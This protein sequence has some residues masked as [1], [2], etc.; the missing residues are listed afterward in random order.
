MLVRV[1][2]SERVPDDARVAA[3]SILRRTGP[4]SP[5]LRPALEKAIRPE[6]SPRLRAAALPLYARLVS[7]AEAEEIARNEMKGPPAARAASAAVWGA[8]AATRPEEAVKP[9]RSMVYDPVVEVRVEAAR[10]YGMLRRE[11]LE[12][13]EKA[14]AD[15][16]PE[17][18]RA[19]LESA[20]VLAP[21][22]PYPVADMLGRAV[23][24]VRPA[25]RK[26]VV[27]ALARMGES[28]PAVVLPPLARAI[29]DSDV[30]TRVAAANGFC[31]LARKNAAA[32]SPYL[33]IAARDD[34]DEVR[35][36]AAACL[37]EVAAGDPKG[38]A[39]MAA[40]LAE[41][42]AG[43]RCA[44][45]PPRRWGG[46]AARPRSWRSR[47]CS[48]CWAIRD[49]EVRV[50]RR[51]GIRDGAAGAGLDSLD[52]RRAPTPTRALEAALVHGDVGERKLI[53]SAAA[54]RGDVGPAAAGG[55]R[56]RRQRSPGGGA[57]GGR[58]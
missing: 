43:R 25:V 35:T 16:S 19:A 51:A 44:S 20:L 12:L 50:V 13:A 49:S 30:A 58:R 26:S 18:E 21:A 29:K 27:E 38:A 3:L 36:A 55:A 15:P 7:P 31:A 48:S 53:V 47:R 39:R 28:R 52:K 17:V 22:N 54:M 33:R 40:E 1:V 8:V 42:G 2:L 32:T 24:T 57:G 41:S 37:D 23:K 9:L 14:L 4:P 46:S 6:T 56:R 5:A 34:H 45:P 11:G 10:A